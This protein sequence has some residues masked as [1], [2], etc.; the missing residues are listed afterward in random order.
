ML[1]MNKEIKEKHAAM[2]RERRVAMSA[3]DAQ[4]FTWEEAQQI[5]ANRKAQKQTE[6]R[7]KSPIY[8]SN[9]HLKSDY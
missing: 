7:V 6:I 5:L 4:F 8:K 9:G 1:A 3:P 2:L